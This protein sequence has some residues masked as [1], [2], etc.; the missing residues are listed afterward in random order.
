MSKLQRL[1]DSVASLS[2]KVDSASK[3]SNPAR[4]GAIAAGYKGATPA[5]QGEIAA[6]KDAEDLYFTVTYS[7]LKKDGSRAEAEKKVAA[8]TKKE[9]EYIVMKMMDKTLEEVKIVSSKP[10]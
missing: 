6:R 8:P 9:A 3:G 7:Y 1:A 4:E 10:S 2:A 5:E